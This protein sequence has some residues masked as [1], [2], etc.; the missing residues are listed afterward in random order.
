LASKRFRSQLGASLAL[1]IAMG[2][3]APAHA[4]DEVDS[5]TRSIAR[6][7]ALQGADA[8]ERQDFETA[9]DRFQRAST[10]VRAPSITVM[11]ARSLV[12]LGRFL[13]ALDRYEETLR[14]PLSA[15]APEAFRLAVDDA[16]TEAIALRA[17]IP[18]LE[19]R[20]S[21]DQAHV[22]VTLDGRPVPEALLN[23][24]RPVDPGSHVLAASAPG[25]TPFQQEFSVNEGEHRVIELPAEAKPAPKAAE[26][27]VMEQ[28][29][30]GS[31][32]RTL[33]IVL[34]GAGVAAVTVGAV[35][36]AIAL[37]R[38]SDLDAVCH[39]GCPASSEDEISSFRLNRTLSYASFG[40]G[41]VAL[42][43]GGY[44]LLTSTSSKTTLAAR[45]SPQS[46]SLTG[47]F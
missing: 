1:V 47:A 15:D 27:R 29:A 12:R 40:L 34:T 32:N 39:P 30:T 10:L 46:V 37:N 13:E 43:I 17:R 19:V 14:L 35:T 21:P 33:G 4:A 3:C 11:L 28:P 44:F 20:T 24:E 8:F 26:P 22:N 9:L 45:V 23:V 25:L 18:R 16:R 31:S 6:E 38:K 36:G 5:E 7:L 42:G 2:V 41:A